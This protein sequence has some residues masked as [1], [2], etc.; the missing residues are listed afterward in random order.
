MLVKGVSH[1][2]SHAKLHMGWCGRTRRAKSDTQNQTCTCQRRCMLE[3]VKKVKVAHAPNSLV[4]Q[5][6]SCRH[7]CDGPSHKHLLRSAGLAKE[8]CRCLLIDDGHT[9]IACTSS[10]NADG[11]RTCGQAH[12]RAVNAC[13][14]VMCAPRAM[15]CAMRHIAWSCIAC[16]HEHAAWQ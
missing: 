13:M 15:P 1:D 2:S 5:P 6:A 12:T 10:R 14:H 11:D 16:P 7:I 8:S 4:D 9:H 3:I